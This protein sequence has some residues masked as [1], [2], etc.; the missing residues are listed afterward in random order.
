MKAALE[1]RGRN[2][3]APGTANTAAIRPNAMLPKSRTARRLPEIDA[4]SV[5]GVRT[6]MLMRSVGGWPRTS[7]AAA[8]AAACTTSGSLLSA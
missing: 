7:V 8:S 4:G 6:E 3:W 5:A 1:G 2:H